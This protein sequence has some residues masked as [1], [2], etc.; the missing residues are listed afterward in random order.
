[1][2]KDLQACLNYVSDRFVYTADKKSI[3]DR[4]NVMKLQD[5]GKFYGDCEDFSLTVMW[6]YSGQ[7]LFK[8]LLNIVLHRYVIWHVKTST[9]EGHAVG[10]IGGRY[11]D[12]FGRKAIHKS[13]K[14]VTRAYGHK[15]KVPFIFPFN[16]LKLIAGYLQK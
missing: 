5:D 15:F 14:E 12:N 13:R 6:Y 16:I 3:F 11:F 4:W 9:G 10:S 1:M 8:F 7:S 2:K